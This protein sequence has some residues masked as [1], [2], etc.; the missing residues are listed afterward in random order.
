MKKEPILQMRT[1]KIK[2]KCAFNK[3]FMARLPDRSEW[4]N[5]LWLTEM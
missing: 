1:E 2:P 5:W 4:E 3:T